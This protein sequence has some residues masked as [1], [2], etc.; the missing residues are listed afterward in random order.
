MELKIQ[1]KFNEGFKVLSRAIEYYDLKIEIEQE[2]LL[3]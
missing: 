2:L 1:M 3:V